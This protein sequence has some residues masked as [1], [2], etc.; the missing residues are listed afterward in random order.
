VALVPAP[1]LV[2]DFDGVLVDGMDEYWWSSRRA[3]LELLGA[4]PQQPLPEAVP[5]AFRQLRPLIHKGWE[6]VLVAAELGRATPAPVPTTAA[7]Y[8]GLLAGA[9]DRW[10]WQ[11]ATL[12]RALEEV[13]ADAIATDRAGWLARHRFYPGVPERLASLAAEGADWLVLTTKGAAFAAELL[14]AAG[15]EP[16]ALYGHEHGSKPEMLLRLRERQRPLWFVEDRRPT[17]EQVRATPGLEAVRCY[18]VSWGY[19]APEDVHR[20]A[21]AGLRWLEPDRF[22]APLADWP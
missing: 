10:G 20:P 12:Q 2:F 4:P 3:A 15:L 5:P 8:A 13:R 16:A 19:L 17:L 22:A 1:L 14:A 7:S 9:L 18:L 11:P 21:A 6:M